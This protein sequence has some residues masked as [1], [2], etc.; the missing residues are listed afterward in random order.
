M[1]RILCYGDSNTWGTNPE[2]GER[3]D[4]NTRYPKVLE[5][6]LGADYEVIEEGFPGRTTVYDT[7][8]DPYVN[9]RKYLYPCLSSHA[10][11]ELVTIMLGTNDL[12]TGVKVNAYYAAAGVERL[13]NLIRHW[14]IDCRCKCPEILLISPPLIDE[15]IKDIP[16]IKEVFDYNYAPAQSRLFRQYYSDVAQTTGCK[17]LAGEDYVTVGCDGV[18]ITAE[19]HIR[20]AKAIF[21]EIAPF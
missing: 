8:V 7:D 2:T 14:S 15:K 10:P 9:G 17:F 1:K 12:S 3:Y 19:S 5:K 16:V 18:H 20:L 13:V 4:E 21:T 11:L 6:L